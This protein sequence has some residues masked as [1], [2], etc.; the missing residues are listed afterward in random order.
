MASI[1]PGVLRRLQAGLG[2]LFGNPEAR[3]AQE[4]LARLDRARDWLREYLTAPGQYASQLDDLLRVSSPGEA[5]AVASL[6]D[7]AAAAQR[8]L[9]AALQEAAAAAD[10]GDWDVV[11]ARL[12]GAERYQQ[13]LEETRRELAQRVRHHIERQRAV[14]RSLQDSGAFRRASVLLDELREAPELPGL[15]KPDVSRFAAARDRLWALIPEEC[16]SE[17][18]STVCFDVAAAEEAA[19]EAIE[20]APQAEAAMTAYFYEAARAH[21]AAL[22]P[23]RAARVAQLLRDPESLRRLREQHPELIEAQP[24]LSGFLF[25]GPD[26]FTLLLLYYLFSA[27]SPGWHGTPPLPPGE[28]P[29]F[30][31]VRAPAE[32]VTRWLHSLPVVLPAADEWPALFEQA[33]LLAG[34]PFDGLVDDEEMAL[35]ELDELEADEADEL[36]AGDVGDTGD[37]A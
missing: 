28:Q 32:A 14:W 3:R 25:G 6:R 2:A 16:R 21:Q 37:W 4:L 10:R 34:S 33:D 30:E 9:E 7:R 1:G 31:L 24:V 23:E 29:D 13:D 12:Q 11:E 20:A 35:A 27:H 22:G 8:A 18:I 15:P 19:R 26:L 5:S 36:D 17:D